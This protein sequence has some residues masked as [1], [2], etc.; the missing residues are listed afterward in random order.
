MACL[1]CPLGRGRQTTLELTRASHDNTLVNRTG[2]GQA[3]RE[4]IS[5]F[6]YSFL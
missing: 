2:V 4:Y 1:H 3:G 6:H 5:R